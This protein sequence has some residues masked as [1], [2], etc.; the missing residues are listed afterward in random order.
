VL[1]Y[2][3]HWFLIRLFDWGVQAENRAFQVERVEVMSG[4]LIDQLRFVMQSGFV[5]IFGAEGGAP[6][7]A[8]CLSPGERIVHIKTKQGDAWGHYSLL[9]IQFATNTGRQSMWYGGNGGQEQN[10][11]ASEADPIISLRRPSQGFCPRITGVVAR[12]Q[13]Q[14]AA[15][16]DDLRSSPNSDILWLS[17]W[18]M[19]QY[20]WMHRTIKIRL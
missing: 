8:F 14:V 4:D 12:S 20:N 18:L 17:V 9:G 15:E 16:H 3:Q 1:K 7:E 13:F 19:M 5:Q 6:R 11:S 2:D 10:F